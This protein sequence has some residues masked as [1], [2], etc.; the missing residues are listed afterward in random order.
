MFSNYLDSARFQKD[1][2]YNDHNHQSQFGEFTNANLE[3]GKD[4]E[5]NEQQN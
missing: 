2:S 5:E 3:D 4:P 1:N